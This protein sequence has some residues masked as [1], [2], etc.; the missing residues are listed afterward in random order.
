L[1]HEEER[2]SDVCRKEVVKVLYHVIRDA[3]QL[4][5]PG[6]EHPHIQSIADDG[7]HLFREHRSTFWSSQVD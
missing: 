1:L 7:A 2:A 6:I 3:G 5:D 4:A